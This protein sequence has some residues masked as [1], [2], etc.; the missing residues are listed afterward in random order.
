VCVKVV[1]LGVYKCELYFWLF[2]CEY[3]YCVYLCIYAC[4]RTCICV[5]VCRVHVHLCLCEY[6]CLCES[7]V[8]CYSVADSLV[9][10]EPITEDLDLI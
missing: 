1:C 4:V 7:W 9:R 8:A 10:S 6:L 2:A 5:H 3:I